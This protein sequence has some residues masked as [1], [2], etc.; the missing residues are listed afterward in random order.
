MLKANEGV[1]LKGNLHTHTHRSDGKMPFD[2]AVRLYENA[3]YDFLAVTDH[4][5]ISEKAQTPD[6]MLLLCGCEYNIGKNVREGI[7]H[8][9]GVGMKTPPQIDR[10][11]RALTAQQIIDG[12]REAGGLAIYAHPAWSLNRADQLLGL[13]GLSGI[14]I[15]NS[16]S[17]FP[18]NCRPYSGL[19]VDQLASMGLLLP[20]VAAD[21]THEYQDDLF[22][23]YVMVHAR[24]KTHEA[25]MEALENGDFYATQGPE[26]HLTVQ[27]GVATVNCSP[28]SRVVFYSDSPWSNE[29]VTSGEGIVHAVCTLMEKETFVRAEVIDREGRIAY[30]SPVRVR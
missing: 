28:A 3:G 29:R 18:H 2:E 10:S 7:Y 24:E 4:W 9:V 5:V 13:T 20:C 15:Y 27:E 22:H 26:I 25:V 1:W 14:E 8:I 30:S 16:T 6:G 17:D 19:Y 12:I 23:G 21:D 11:N